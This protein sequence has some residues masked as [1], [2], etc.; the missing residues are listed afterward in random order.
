MIFAGSCQQENLEPAAQEN[1]VTYTVEL[2]DVQTKA[3][4]D[5]STVNQLIYEVWKTET[6]GQTDLSANA[7]R[8]YQ[9]ETVLVQRE[10][11]KTGAVVTFNLVQDQEYTILFWAQVEGKNPYNTEWLTNVHYN[12]ISEEGVVD[13]Y[14]SNKE[15]YAA[16]YA[17]DC[18][19]DSDLKSKTVTLTRP[20]AQLNLGTLNTA[21]KYTVEM[22]DSE[23]T[24]TKVPTGFNVA[25]KEALG[26]GKVV[27][28]YNTVPNDPNIITVNG[29]TY[30]YAAMN[31]LFAD[32]NR[33]T[34]TVTYNIKSTLTSDAG[35][36]EVT[37]NVVVNNTVNH[38]PYTENY[39]TNIVGNLLTSTT[40][41]EVIVDAS[42][43][44]YEDEPYI[45]E[46]WNGTELTQPKASAEDSNIYEIEYPSE[47]AWLAA[48]VNGT[49]EEKY[50]RSAVAANDFAGKTFVLT[51]DVDLAGHYWT[52]IGSNDKIFKGT[53]DGQGHTVK[54]LVITGN[55]SNVG[56]FGVTH[57]GEIKNLTVENAEVSGRLNV[58]VVAGQPYT[59]KY[60]NITVKGHV[61]VNGMAYVGGV[62]GK[63]AY[64][65]WTDITVDADETSY[66]KAHSIEN[67][68]AYR[69]YV[70]GVVGFNGE[71]SHKFS[72]ITSNINVQ[73]STQDVGGLFG[74]AH[75]GNQFENCT[76]TGNVEI[77][78]A[79]EVEEAQEIGGIAGVWHNQTGNSVSMTDCEF[80]GTLTTNVE[81]VAFYYNGLVGKPYGNGEGKLVI[82]GAIYVASATELERVANAAT[83]ATTI[84]FGTNL[85][86]NITIV[87]KDGVNLTID[88]DK[89]KYDGVITVNG[90]ARANGEETLT[91]KNIK[92]ETENTDFTFISAP[93]KIDGKYNY[94]HN[95]TIEGCT[96]T[97]NQTVGSA[98][99]TGT[100]NF[101][102]KNCEA[103]NMH[104]ILQAQSVDNTVVVDNVTV[105]NSKSG[106]SFGNTAKA[107]ITNS[108]IN[109]SGYGIRA[110][111]TYA[112]E[113]SLEVK[114]CTINAYVPV[115]VRKLTSDAK[116]FTANVDAS[117][118][119][120]KGC[121]YDV[122]LGV[123]EFEAGVEPVKPACDF[124]ID[125]VDSEF[126][127]FP[128]AFPVASWDEFTAALAAGEDWIKLTDNIS[129]ATSYSIMADVVVDLNGKTIEI[130]SPTEKLN[131]GNK[132][133]AS[134]YRPTVT[135]KNGNL[136]CKVYAQTGNL[137]LTDIKF[138]GSIAYT[139]DAQGVISVGGAANLLAERCDM[140]SVK[141]DAAETRPRALS[142]EGRSSGYLILRDCNFPSS[143]DGTG[144]F[145]KTKMIR[146]YITPLSGN[147]TLEIANC[148]FGVACNVDLSA[149]YV[150]SNM[151]LTGCS[152]GFTFTVSRS[153]DSLTE[154]ETAIMKAI[155]K[156]NSGT[157][158]AYYNGTL[159]TY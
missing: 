25:T 44:K 107:T 150:W 15:D 55:N 121:D 113:V 122:V 111:G 158:K 93:S 112:R 155:K 131:T 126:T 99:F 91:F 118:T 30:E 48:A 156:N 19:S 5:A 147:A 97:G 96:F 24:V 81:G 75:Y 20:F 109:V 83:E 64:A 78:A 134:A 6:K 42:W 41:Y 67:G 149:S 23:V 65:D 77:Y 94:S 7:V 125:G 35:E 62:G 11:G 39:R 137:T 17:V 92:F 120:E 57:D 138:G 98:S 63:N 142:S 80:T 37:E 136:N 102:M 28:N 87:Q 154:E 133:N 74:I 124:S 8:L 29:V 49:L 27:F 157:I 76:C 153:K 127:T 79:E 86:G 145:V 3:I 116:K 88:G 59:S 26:E 146:T 58:G 123:N 1:T 33:R 16:F 114:G 135:I 139:S 90:N 95:V 130:S 10:D 22:V 129:N 43:A 13:A 2:P 18:V 50:T 85:N 148:K 106:V 21:D 73:G 151:N 132:N 70:G 53:F 52:P 46:A 34:T 45:V 68:T 31:Y 69:T 119:F 9:D 14:Y 141:A 12:E 4:G 40:Q 143:S 110:E 61:E 36:G 103:T 84:K 117:N 51:K 128:A 101:K 82:D 38:V 54:N 140:A 56:L 152:G 144:T 60:T 115:V 72:N 32:A 66:V 71:G 105:T 47:L 104:S 108:N 100:Y 159:V 89:K